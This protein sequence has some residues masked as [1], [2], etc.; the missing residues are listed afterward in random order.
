MATPA[1]V[2]EGVDDGSPAPLEESG[3]DR[4]RRRVA[5]HIEETALLLFAEHGYSEVTMARIAAVSGV[6]ARTVPRYFPLKEDLVLAVPRARRESTLEAMRILDLS[7]DPIADMIEVFKSLARQHADELEHFTLW[8]RAIAT[9][10]EM[11]GRAQGDLFLESVDELS[12]HVARTLGADRRTDL[13]PVVLSM[14]LLSAVDGAT[15][16]WHERGGVDDWDDLLDG[17]LA[18]LR[19]G[20]V[21]ATD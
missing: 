9:A 17:V 2:G 5:H 15:R 3:W 19:T 18:A 7:R 11:R 4:R 10:P 16:F 6:S 14:A 13:R 1:S 8:T 12:R 21:G 20:F